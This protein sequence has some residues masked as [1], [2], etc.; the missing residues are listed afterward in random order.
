MG[1]TMVLAQSQCRC[2]VHQNLVFLEQSDERYA[3]LDL[4]LSEANKLAVYVY[5]EV[6]RFD[7]YMSPCVI[8]TVEQRALWWV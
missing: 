1:G 5:H 6:L 7:L 2:H 8:R 4:R 3:C